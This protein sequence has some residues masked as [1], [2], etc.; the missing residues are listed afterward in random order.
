MCFKKDGKALD[1]LDIVSKHVRTTE[2]GEYLDENKNKWNCKYSGYV[3]LRIK[4]IQIS[5]S[6]ELAYLEEN[7]KMYGHINREE[8]EIKEIYKI[9]NVAF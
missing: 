7:F 9:V 5:A 6:N 3:T 1:V 8:N 4:P 2:P